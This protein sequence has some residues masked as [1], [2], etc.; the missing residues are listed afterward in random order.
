MKE[1]VSSTWLLPLSCER[2][3]TSTF[4]LVSPKEKEEKKSFLL[5]LSLFFSSFSL[6]L[7]SQLCY[8]GS[9]VWGGWGGE[10]GGG[11]LL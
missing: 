3:K 10:S 1:G 4:S 6:Y 8:T 5:P 11:T 2:R 9:Q 7:F